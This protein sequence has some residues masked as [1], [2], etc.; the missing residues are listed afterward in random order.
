MGSWMDRRGR[1]GRRQE[2]RPARTA[3]EPLQWFMDVRLSPSRCQTNTDATYPFRGS[4][5]CCVRSS[6]PGD[7]GPQRALTGVLSLC[8]GAGPARPGSHA[9][10]GDLE[11]Q[12]HIPATPLHACTGSEVR[13]GFLEGGD[14]EQGGKPLP[15]PRLG[16]LPHWPAKPPSSSPS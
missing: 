2:G 9:D 1:V 15:A 3:D 5:L 11:H 14:W 12:C 6:L 8:S 16:S 13:S 7:A 4:S 10:R